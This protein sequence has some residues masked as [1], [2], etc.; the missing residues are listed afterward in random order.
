MSTTVMPL[1][2]L[3]S[4]RAFKRGFNVS[5]ISASDIH[6]IAK[7]ILRDGLLNPLTVTRKGSKFLVVDGAK[8]LAALH[9]LSKAGRLPRSL[10]RVPVSIRTAEPASSS[11]N[12]P[13]LLS[14]VELAKAIMGAVSDGQTQSQICD[15]FDCSAEIVEYALSLSNLNP[16]IREYFLS[17]HLS[18]EQVA[19]FATLENPDA[20]WRLLQE[21]GPFAHA[22]DVIS[23]ILSGQSV[24]ELADGNVMILPSRRDC[25]DVK[26]SGKRAA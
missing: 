19:A 22:K 1:S 2:D 4:E 13:A 12:R 3:Y 14:D 21:L 23:A 7:R 18:L 8:R 6:R 5:S 26:P 24:I 25:A 9:I 20:Q 17:G 11:N 16:Q 10:T 15:R